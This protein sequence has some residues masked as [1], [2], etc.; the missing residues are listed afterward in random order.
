MD[1]LTD[2]K[3]RNATPA[4][5]EYAIAD[6]QGLSVVVRPQWDQ[7][8][9]LSLPFRRQA[10]EYVFCPVGDSCSPSGRHVCIHGRQ[11][12]GRKYAM[13][14]PARWI[15]LYEGPASPG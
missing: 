5:K 2:T 14:N 8:V 3:V 13:L 15:F 6:G 9:A 1:E 4:D 7:A 11:R 12:L 10:Q